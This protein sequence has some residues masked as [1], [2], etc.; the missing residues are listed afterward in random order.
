MRLQ[1]SQ[2]SKQF[3]TFYSVIESMTQNLCS[4]FADYE[5]L[6]FVNIV[7]VVIRHH[8]FFPEIPSASFSKKS[9]LINY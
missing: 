2:N 9:E 6:L 4:N 3:L 8:N 5:H 7:C 1:Y